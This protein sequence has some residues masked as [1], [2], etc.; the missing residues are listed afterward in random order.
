MTTTPS[1]TSDDPVLRLLRELL[2]REEARAED[3]KVVRASLV[4][5]ETEASEQ[6]FFR[7][8]TK[9][10]IEEVKG[11]FERQDGQLIALDQRISGNYRGQSAQN[12][13][14]LGELKGFSERLGNIERA[15]VENHRDT[16]VLQGKVIEEGDRLGFRAAQ[17]EGVIQSLATATREVRTNLEVVVTRV[18]QLEAKAAGG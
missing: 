4:K 14:V 16:M 6:R 15:I 1:E 7:E 9:K 13:L 12:D 18:N 8:R 17:Y 3:L 11:A 2:R 10:D 5:L